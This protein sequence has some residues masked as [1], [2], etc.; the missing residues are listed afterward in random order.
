[1][2]FCLVFFCLVIRG[3]SLFDQRTL[4]LKGKSHLLSLLD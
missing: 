2:F 4:A 3:L 1:V